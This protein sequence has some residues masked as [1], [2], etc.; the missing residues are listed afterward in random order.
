MLGIMYAEILNRKGEF[1]MKKRIWIAILLTISLLLISCG[2]E[3]TP[4]WSDEGSS[5]AVLEATS[6]SEVS[7]AEETSS[8]PAESS[9]ASSGTAESSAVDDNSDA[10]DTIGDEP[11]PGDSGDSLESSGASSEA[12]DPSRPEESSKGNAPGTESSET[13]K[14]PP[15]DTGTGSSHKHSYKDTVVKPTCTEKGYTLHKC[16][17]G[18]SY[19]DHETE[20]L[21]H[22]IEQKIT[23]EPT[24]KKRGLRSYVCTDCGYVQEEYE[25]YSFNEIEAMYVERIIYWVNYYRAQEGAKLA[26]KSNKLTELAQ[27]RANQALQGGKHIGHNLDDIALAAAATKCGIYFEDYPRID[28]GEIIPAHWEATG[29]EA[30][31]G[32]SRAVLLEVN[33]SFSLHSI[34]MDAQGAVNRFH[35]SAGHW[36]YVG[37]KNASYSECTYIGVGI[38]SGGCYIIVNDYDPD[39]TG[40]EHYYLDENGDLQFEWVKP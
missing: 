19:T 14:Q 10:S 26:T 36:A 15:V 3:P 38:S 25:L 11:E 40:Y 5:S 34:D 7:G 27:Y 6:G 2:A 24:A 20:A 8:L 29:Q 37:A 13:S 28:T 18:E 30:Y 4:E 17:C 21:G 9:G 32:F 35:T 39:V 31:T 1:K 23:K 33:D 12:A 16:S 22:L